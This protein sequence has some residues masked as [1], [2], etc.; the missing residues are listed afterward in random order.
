MTFRAAAGNPADAPPT[1]LKGTYRIDLW[2]FFVEIDDKN[3]PYTWPSAPVIVLDPFE[4]TT[5]N[6]DGQFG[7]RQAWVGEGTNI[8]RCNVN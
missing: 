8:I 5:T 1:L 2:A 3:A 7:S 6:I 4:T